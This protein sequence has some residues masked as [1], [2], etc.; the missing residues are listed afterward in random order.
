VC[1]D[2]RY[3]ADIGCHGI[4]R[5]G[6]VSKNASSA[7]QFG[8][9]VS[10][11]IADWLHKGFADGPY[12][13]WEVPSDAKINCILCREKPNGSVRIILN[14]SSPAGLSVNDG[15]NSDDFPAIM[16]STKKWL[17]VLDTVGRGAWM[18]K[19]DWS[20]A[21]KHLHVK[22][23]DLNLQWFSWLGKFFRE[24]CLIFGSSSSPGLY[25]RLAKTVLDIVLRIA[26]FP[27]AWICQH[28]DDTA[29]ACPSNDT[30]IFRF[31]ETYSWVAKKTWHKTSS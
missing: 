9:H 8:R 31:D 25:D 7:F 15:I 29:A 28:L 20:D 19:I 23:D 13:E 1:Q 11:A 21:Y 6:S 5:N 12:E 24:L 16:S 14:L 4:A 30:A 3:G 18:A 27:K 10:D 22:K 2:L 26:N 17:E